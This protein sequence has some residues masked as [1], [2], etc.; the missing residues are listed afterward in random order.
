M[1]S[2]THLISSDEKGY[3]T[4]KKINYKIKQKNDL[5]IFTIG[6]STTEQGETDNKKTWSNLLANKLEKLRLA[7]TTFSSG[8][9]M[10]AEIM[11]INASSTEIF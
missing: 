3:R 2:G 6:A 11:V 4:N 9:T 10:P 8:L 1:F 5:R 7:V